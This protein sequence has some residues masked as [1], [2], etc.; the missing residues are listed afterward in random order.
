[1]EQSEFNK[2]MDGY[3]KQNESNILIFARDVYM[4]ATF[5]GVAFLIYSILI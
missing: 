1:M 3:K 2:L 5:C 4:V